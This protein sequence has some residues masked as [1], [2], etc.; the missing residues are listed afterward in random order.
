[1]SKKDI[2]RNFRDSVFKRDKYACVMCGKKSSPEKIME[3]MDCHHVMDRS[4]M[5]NQGY[6]PLNGITLCKD[7]CHLNAE[8]FHIYG[9]PLPG[10]SPEDLYKK[11]GSS[12]DLAIEASEKLSEE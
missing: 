5:P 2:R 8:Y 4:D 12:L 1:M 9:K 11:I 3:E 6:T 7:T 10:W